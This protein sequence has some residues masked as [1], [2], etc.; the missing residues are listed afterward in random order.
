MIPTTQSLEQWLRHINGD[1]AV[2][3]SGRKRLTEAVELNRAGEKIVNTFGNREFAAAVGFVDMRGF[4]S[5]SFGLPPSQVR[6][7]ASP[8]VNAVITSAANR[9]WFVDKTIGDEVMLI[10]P[11]FG[12]DIRLALP[13]LAVGNDIFVEVISLVADILGTL[14]SAG[15]EEH[16]SAGFGLGRLILDRI[17][18]S[19]YAE[20]TCY[21]NVVNTAKRLQ[22]VA[23]PENTGDSHLLVLGA[24][25]SEVPSINDKLRVWSTICQ[26][27]ERL[28]FGSPEPQKKELKG[29]GVIAFVA[30]TIELKEQYR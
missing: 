27:V 10:R 1:Q 29:V 12:E 9:H 22:S 6:D 15:V 18:T 2:P 21:G 28:A 24:S 11:D 16:L 30:S 5:K 23:I 7:V 26:Q 4:T 3:P 13:D 25:E 17:G 14:K 20:W 8:F 19:E